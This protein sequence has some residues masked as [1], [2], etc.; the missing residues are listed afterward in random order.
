MSKSPWRPRLAPSGLVLTAPP[1]QL[2]NTAAEN[3]SLTPALKGA[4]EQIER[5]KEAAAD[6]ERA[7]SQVPCPILLN[8]GRLTTC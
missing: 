7:V 4:K 6:R 5:L 8:M 1:L 3:A 2:D